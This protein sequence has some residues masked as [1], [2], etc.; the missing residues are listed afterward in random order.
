MSK[1][2]ESV[3]RPAKQAKPTKMCLKCGRVRDI[4]EF[5]NNRDWVDQLG[6]DVWCKDCVS[7]CATKDEIREYFWENHREWYERIWDA[8]KRKAEKLALNNFTFQKAPEERR[9]SILERLTCQ[10]VPSC[11]STV[12]NYKYVENSKDGKDL[13]YAEAKASGVIQEDDNDP[14]SKVYSRE[15]NGY[16]KPTELEYLESYYAGLDRDYT[17]DTENLRDY[18]RKLSKASLQADKAQDDFMAGK[19]DFS[20]VKDA[21]TL[22]DMLSKSAN[23]AAC[24]RKPGDNGGIGSWSELTFKLE[25]SG[26]PCTRKIEWPKDDVDKT[27]EEFRYIV[28]ALGIDEN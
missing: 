23:F 14:D 8:A 18:A 27:L 13:T 4:E 3:G 21:N 22:F 12:A 19:C 11:M 25:S 10:Q 1:V 2:V 17:L 5:Y 15:F 9:K 20:V 28:E 24:K 16:F 7:R 26:H 6:K